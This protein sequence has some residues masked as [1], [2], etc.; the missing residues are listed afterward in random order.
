LSHKNSKAKL[1]SANS[2][3]T[4]SNNMNSAKK[5]DLIRTKDWNLEFF[6]PPASIL[7]QNSKFQIQFTHDFQTQKLL[8]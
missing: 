2:P 8:F 5:K 1:F 6:K 4:L 3:T 7:G